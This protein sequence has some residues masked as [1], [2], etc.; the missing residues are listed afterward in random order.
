MFILSCGQ[1]GT[2]T[3]EKRA[4]LEKKGA[5]QLDRVFRISRGVGSPGDDRH[6]L[7]TSKQSPNGGT[8]RDL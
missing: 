3:K 4:R 2:T 5:R 7:T 6:D 8:D 1:K